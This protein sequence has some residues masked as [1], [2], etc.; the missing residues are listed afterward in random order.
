MISKQ[1]E[2]I[3]FGRQWQ[4]EIFLRPNRAKGCHQ[5]DITHKL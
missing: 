3:P 1:L 4:L 5:A 2:T